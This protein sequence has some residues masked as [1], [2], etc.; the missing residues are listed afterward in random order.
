MRIGLSTATFFGRVLTENALNHIKS[1]GVD[2]AE[3]F[4]TTFSEYEEDYTRRLAEDKHGVDVYSVHSLNNHYEPELFNIV[5]R[6]REDADK[7]FNKVLQGAE[8]LGASYYTFHGP[9]RLKVT[10]YNLDYKRIG[11]RTE[12]LCAKAREYGVQLS[13]ENVS[14]AFY[15][16]PGFF[17]LLKE[18]APSLKGCLDIKQAMQAYRNKEGLKSSIQLTLHQ[19]EDLENYT[20]QYIDDMGESLVN[21]HLSDYDAYGKLCPPG[22]GI[23]RFNN[24]VNKLQSIGYNGPMMIE[25]YS[26][27][28]SSYDEIINSVQYLQDIITEGR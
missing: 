28:Y 6:T 23:F 19:I 27:D 20:Y 5:K 25:L 16:S 10:E 15:N 26:G 2:I 12:E 17:T 11:T 8:N 9:S 24:L 18:Y 14:W 13:Y 1:L 21:V 22:K 4:L 3:V 7:L